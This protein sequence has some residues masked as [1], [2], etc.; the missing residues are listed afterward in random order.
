VPG[1]DDA[2]DNGCCLFLE[3]LRKIIHVRARQLTV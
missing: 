3:K 1:R 2:R